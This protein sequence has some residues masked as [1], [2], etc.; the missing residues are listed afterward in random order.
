ME[1]TGEERKKIQE[2]FTDGMKQLGLDASGVTLN[3]RD[4][5]LILEGNREVWQ[6]VV[7]IGHMAAKLPGVT[8][9]VNH[10]TSDDQPEP[11]AGNTPEEKAAELARCE[12]M[13]VVDHAQVVI[14]GAG[15][16][17]CGIA[18]ELSKYKLDILVLE[19]EEDI[20]CGTTKSNNGMVHSGYD[21]RHGSL[22]AEMNVRGNAMY[23]QWAQDLHFAFNRTGSFVLAFTE[24]EH[25]KLKYY[26]EN[27]TK[28]GVPGI[29]LITGDEA[30]AIEP[31]ISDEAKWALWTPSAGYV[32]PYEVT[33][34]LME[35]AMDNGARLRLNCRILDIKRKDSK[36]AELI[37]TQGRITCDY[38]IDAAGLYADEIARML[39]DE[40]FTIHPR[41]G[42]LVIY[43]KENKGKIHTYSGQAP[44]A[45]TKG[46]GPQETPE[47]TLLFG[48]SA[49][50][51]PEKD[52]LGVDQDDL[53]F[54]VDKGMFLVKNVDR[55]SLITFFSGN[56]AATYM[57]DFIIQKSDRLD[58]V[59]YA[60]GIQS[61]GLASSPAIAERVEHIFLDMAENVQ[62][63]EAWNPIREIKKPIRFCSMEEREARIE[64][65]P[66]YGRIIC[67]CET[68][69]EG[70]I[71][72]A[73]HG[74]IPATNVD[75]VK[76]RTRAGMG[77]CQGGFCQAKVLEILARELGIP[78]TAVT[79]KGKGSNILCGETRLGEIDSTGSGFAGLQIEEMHSAG[80]DSAGTQKEEN[81]TRQ[82]EEHV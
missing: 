53:D 1:I 68:V 6:Q 54:V 30:R 2:A 4:D 56:R 12:A 64:E 29:A 44:G 28:N 9:L 17:G 80:N 69:T 31:N 77:R 3:F 70:E 33:L 74:K 62:K 13:D 51:V 24:E 38:L 25:E 32:E 40:F 72:D 26:L 50:E 66:L 41:R 67:R 42:T 18:R 21:S 76:R 45:Y 60:A 82:V 27:G 61:P 48:P 35:N 47:G 58:N 36:A 37:T 49:K 5:I 55:A 14:I 52:D 8:K 59:I 22:K 81:Q 63:D 7:D 23:T 79:L 34:A 75:A 71:V 19:K 39:D 43:D 15:V 20:S 11:E 65:N 16:T 57:E 73:I 46:G 78:E 10:L